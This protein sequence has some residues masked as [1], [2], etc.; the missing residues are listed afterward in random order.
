MEGLEFCLQ[1]ALLSGILHSF[2]CHGQQLVWVQIRLAHLPH[3]GD[4][5]IGHRFLLDG[6]A[7]AD[8]SLGE[9]LIG[10]AD[11]VQHILSLGVFPVENRQRVATLVAEDQSFQQEVI[12]PAPG[13][14]RLFTSIRTF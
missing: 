14:L 6:M 12:G 2:L 13:V 10:A 3:L 4:H 8:P 1:A 5:Y 7:G 9:P 11:E